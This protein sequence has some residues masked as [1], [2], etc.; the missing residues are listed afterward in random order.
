MNIIFMF[1]VGLSRL[2]QFDTG[3]ILYGPDI[4]LTCSIPYF[5]SSR[6]NLITDRWTTR[7]VLLIGVWFIGAFISDI[8]DA[9]PAEDFLRG[10]SKIVFFCTDLIGLILLTKRD[11]RLL[12][13]FTLGLC[14]SYLIEVELFPNQLMQEEP[15]KF[16]YSQGLTPIVVVL[17]STSFVRSRFSLM[18]SATLLLGIA[19]INLAFN[20]RSMFAISSLVGLL[21]LVKAVIDMRPERRAR[22]N[23]VSFTVLMLGVWLASSGLITVYS[24]AASSGI[25]GIEAQ[26]KYV[27]QT[28]GDLNLLQAGRTDLLCRRKQLQTPP[29]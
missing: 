19:V 8:Y 27:Y 4:L 22:F 28:S 7:V 9:T 21:C 12:V 5:I 25:L 20:F 24:E 1:F 14:C 17:A 2:L 15:W 10:W 29:Y 26:E 13:S 16:G 11:Y 3:G 23:P 6:A 18:G